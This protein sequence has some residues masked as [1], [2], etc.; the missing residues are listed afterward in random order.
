MKTF[1]F[2]LGLTRGL[3]LVRVA[4]RCV[5]F[6]GGSLEDLAATAFLFLR[7][8]PE[9]LEAVSESPVSMMSREMLT[10]RCDWVPPLRLAFAGFR[11]EEAGLRDDFLDD[12]DDPF[13][14]CK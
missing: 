12:R 9:A 5:L 4:L 1:S 7:G 8:V 10:V 6:A 11:D 3:A 14:D 13:D 2:L